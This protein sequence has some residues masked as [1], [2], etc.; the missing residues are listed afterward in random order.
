MLGKSPNLHQ[1]D[2]FKPLLTDFIDLHHELVALSDTIDWKLIE[3]SFAPL[4]SH[5]GKPSKPVRLMAGILFLKQMYN[6]GDEVVVPM[7]QSN[8]YMQYFC[9]E[10]FFQWEMPCDPSDLVHFRNRIGTKGAE[11]LFQ[12][13]KG[14]FAKEIEK[15]EEVLVDT[16]V[17]QKNITFPTD[18]KL[19][20][21]IIKNCWKIADKE[22]VNLRQT[23]TQTL[24][25]LKLKLRFANHPKRFKEANKA[26]R[27]LKTIAG[28]LVRDIE[29][30]LNKEQLDFYLKSIELFKRVLAQNR[31]SKDKVYSLHEPETSC[32]AKGKPHKPYEFGSKVSLA[33]IP[34]LNI[35]V[36]IMTFR[37]NP[38][39]SK[40]L[41]PALAQ[42]EKGGKVF[43]TAIVDRGYRGRKCIG[44]TEIVFPGGKEDS[45]L[46]QYQRNKKRKQCK[47]RAAVE[48]IIG[49]V[50]H[51]CRMLTSYLKG[52]KGDEMNAIL[53]ATAF[54]LRQW[55]YKRKKSLSFMPIFISKF[56]VFLK[57]L[58][59]I[60]TSIFFSRSPK[61]SC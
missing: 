1:P 15:A 53:A 21:K 6:V 13:I 14:L 10:A 61:V 55:I 46:T 22:R 9:G 19:Q 37:G 45:K 33:V 30:K 31:N 41:E 28:R 5:T 59:F 7:W 36:G 12:I 58:P 52:T 51:S 49:H 40:T 4:Y 50:K 42:I 8:P 2:L 39:D 47:S 34:K 44:K 60:L 20:I 35:V 48:P 54:N 38:N 56:L 27:R 16:T 26:R 18:V 3:E 43:K 24:E 29:R 11:K 57:G 32:I 25:K 17:Q 23:Y